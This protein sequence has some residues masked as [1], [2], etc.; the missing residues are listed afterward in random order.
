MKKNVS[1][2]ILLLRKD[3]KRGDEKLIH[4]SDYPLKEL[5]KTE[6]ICK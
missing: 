6:Y 1:D 5:G 2:Q 3:D 4:Y